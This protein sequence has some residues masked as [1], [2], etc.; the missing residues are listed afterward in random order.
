MSNLLMLMSM[1][2]LSQQAVGLTPLQHP[3]VVALLDFKAAFEN[4]DQVLKS[5]GNATQ[6][7][8]TSNWTGIV[9]SSDPGGSPNRVTEL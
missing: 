7:P 9:C 5:W 2:L 3:D 6:D 1:A 4:G 8:C